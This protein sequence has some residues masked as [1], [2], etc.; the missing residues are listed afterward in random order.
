MSEVIMIVALMPKVPVIMLMV[1][2]LDILCNVE[3]FFR[4]FVNLLLE[5]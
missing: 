1:L 5:L 4:C 3:H 2:V